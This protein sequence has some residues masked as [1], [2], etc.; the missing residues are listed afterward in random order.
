MRVPRLPEEDLRLN[1]RLNWRG[2]GEMTGV[3][4]R[5]RRGGEVQRRRREEEREEQMTKERQRE[6]RQHCWRLEAVRVHCVTQRNENSANT[7]AYRNS[8]FRIT[9]M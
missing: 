9:K 6:Q 1:W 8:G 7:A 3:G 2:E 4:R 5:R